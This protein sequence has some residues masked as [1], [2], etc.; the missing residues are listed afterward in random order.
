MWRTYLRA[1]QFVSKDLRLSRVIDKFTKRAKKEILQIILAG[2]T[3]AVPDG[4]WPL[5]S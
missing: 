1:P 4:R 2:A 5:K 3:D